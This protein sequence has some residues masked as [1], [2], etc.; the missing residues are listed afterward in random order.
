[1]IAVNDLGRMRYRATWELQER[2]HEVVLNGGPET[3]FIVEHEPVITLGRREE[4]IRN[5]VTSRE[6]LER[7]GIELVHS[8]RG[9]DITYH[10]PG[11]IVA[12][13][14]IRLT[15]HGYSVSGYVHKLESIILAML[16]EIGIAGQT[17]PAAVGVWVREGDAAAKIGAIGVRVRRGV[18]LHGLALNV[19]DDLSGFGHI[20]PCGLAGRPVTSVRKILGTSAPAFADVKRILARHLGGI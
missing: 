2:A 3:I 10:G 12:Y 8:D 4:S 13:P 19:S 20:V 1:V 11:Q 14:I 5:L 9:G 16:A 7:L 15:A 6:E 18:S 17:D